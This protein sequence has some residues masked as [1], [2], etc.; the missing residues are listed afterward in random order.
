MTATATPKRLTRTLSI[1]DPETVFDAPVAAA[2]VDDSFDETP[3]VDL[4]FTYVR[5]IGDGRLLSA[6]EEAALARRKDAGDLRA[7][8]ELVERNLRLVMS[9]ARPYSAASGVSLLDLIQEGNVGL[10]RAVEKF[11]HTKGF[12]LSTYATWWIKQAIS[13]AI[14][15]QGRTIRLPVHV[16][17]NLKRVR[18]AERRLRQELGRTATPEELSTATGLGL[19]KVTALLEIVDDPISLDVSVGDGDSDIADL[20]EDQN[21]TR[22]DAAITEGDV[23]FDLRQALDQ[24]HDQERQVVELR[25]GLDDNGTRTL[26]QVSISLGCTRERVRQVEGRALSALAK[27]NPE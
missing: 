11:D 17:D 21:A 14:A 18:K 20:V 27:A 13:R 9:I 24:L 26:D 19:K 23:S 12:K 25:F 7:K 6:G 8:Q 22:P 16:V 3:E 1:V 5:Q 2:A 10:M 4:L 15:D